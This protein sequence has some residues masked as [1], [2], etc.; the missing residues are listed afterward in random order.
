MAAI[1]HEASYIKKLGFS[2]IENV[3]VVAAIVGHVLFAQLKYF[4]WTVLKAGKIL[5][6][7]ISEIE[8]NLKQT[9]EINFGLFLL[10]SYYIFFKLIL[11]SF[12]ASLT[13]VQ[14]LLPPL[15]TTLRKGECGRIG[16]VGG[17]RVYTGAP[18][19]SA[20]TALKVVC[21]FEYFLVILKTKVGWVLIWVRS[22]WLNKSTLFHPL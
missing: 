4:L 17:S 20:I 18:Y 3:L 12:A 1:T 8:Q 15:N 16:V 6:H 11:S 2:L 22:F 13:A 9:P 7:S 14:E 5:A 21:N 19:F 10:L